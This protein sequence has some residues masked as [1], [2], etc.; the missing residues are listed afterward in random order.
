MFFKL[1]TI[2]LLKKLPQK[3][4]Y[5]NLLRVVSTRVSEYAY[6]SF[7]RIEF[8]S[9]IPDHQYRSQNAFTYPQNLLAPE[10][11]VFQYFPIQSELFLPFQ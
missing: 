9:S 2:L 7:I 5:L 8:D 3:R 1:K 10:A 4:L 11:V 6:G